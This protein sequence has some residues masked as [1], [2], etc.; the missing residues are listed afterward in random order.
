VSGGKWYGHLV[1]GAGLKPDPRSNGL[2]DPRTPPFWTQRP[3]ANPLYF[4]QATYFIRKYVTQGAGTDICRKRTR[5][6]CGHL[7]NGALLETKELC[8]FF[9]YGHES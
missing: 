3:H 6:V 1:L 2:T 8:T 9:S 5:N 7:E 4:I